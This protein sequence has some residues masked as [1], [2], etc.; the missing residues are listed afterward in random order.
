[1]LTLGILLLLG[2]AFYS[3][4]R[5]GLAMQLVY[6]VGYF[7]TF[8]IARTYYQD[9]APSLELLIPYPAVTEN[10]TM[11]FFDQQ[12]SLNLDQAFYAATAFLIITFIGWLAT[13]FIAIFFKKLTYIPILKQFDWVAGGILSFIVVYVGIFLILTIASYV[14]MEAVQNQFER[15]EVA[16]SIVTN[17]P[18]LSSMMENLWVTQ[19][20]G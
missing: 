16:R 7:A 12:I 11:V 4:A 3:G 20:I 15:S 13:R 14:P 1:M 10:A 19:I 17:T 18:I 9:L 6:T 2:I 5:R 8:I